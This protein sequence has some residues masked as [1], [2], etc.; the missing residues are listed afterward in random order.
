[1]AGAG[2]INEVRARRH[3]GIES[4]ARNGREYSKR[5]GV[6]THAQL[7]AALSRFELGEI[8]GAE[9]AQGGMFGQNVMLRTTSGEWVLRGAQHSYRQFP[10]ERCYSRLIHERTET[11]APWPYLL[12]RSTELFGWSYA[13]M[14]RIPGVALNDPGVQDSLAPDAR[15]EIARAMGEHLGRLQSATWDQPGDFSY[16]ADSIVALSQP[17]SEWFETRVRRWLAQCLEATATTGA[18]TE[19]DVAWVESVIDE[20]RD[21]LEEPFEPVIVHT[22]YTEGNVV[23]EPDED[24]NWRVNGIFDLAESYIGDGEYDLARSGAWYW[25]RLGPV[26]LQGFVQAYTARRPLRP[27]YEQRFPLYMLQDRLIFWEYGQRNKM[28]FRPGLTLRAW[29]APAV[30]ITLPV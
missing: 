16:E 29:A 17:Y 8:L 20:A 23:G 10:S 24:G 13:L 25:Q 1:M 9:P 12:E 22:D 18:T 6:L 26:G 2:E 5:L 4:A 3:A 11:D 27:G 14:P 15:M 30:E 21:A 7:Q 19:H 28:W